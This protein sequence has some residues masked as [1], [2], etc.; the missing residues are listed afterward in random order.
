M[1]IKK[2]I[3]PIKIF[4]HQKKEDDEEKIKIYILNE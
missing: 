1:T 2:H 4:L 3:T